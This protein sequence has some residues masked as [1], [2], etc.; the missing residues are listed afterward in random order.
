MTD[1]ALFL[2]V[3]FGCLIA[4]FTALVWLFISGLFN[5]HSDRTR[6][7]AIGFDQTANAALGGSEDE[8][9]SG[10]AHRERQSGV[11]WAVCLCRLLDVI[12]P[13]HCRNSE[14]V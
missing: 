2:L 7:L 3:W 10:R 11:Q 1:R 6:R 5:P 9:I 8:T 12:D 13:N 4:G 14:G